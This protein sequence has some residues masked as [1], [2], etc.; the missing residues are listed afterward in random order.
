MFYLQF[1]RTA[2]GAVFAPTYT[3][4]KMAYHKIQVYFIIKNA[5]DLW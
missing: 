2:V 3:N 5:F 1:K 4:L